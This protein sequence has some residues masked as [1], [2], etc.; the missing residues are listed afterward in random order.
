MIFVFLL[1]V[2]FG[3][4]SGSLDSF[5]EDPMKIQVV[6]SKK[7]HALDL[8]NHDIIVGWSMCGG[9]GVK[10][11]WLRDIVIS[12]ENECGDAQLKQFEVIG[13]FL[14]SFV[15]L[16]V[17]GKEAFDFVKF[18]DKSRELAVK[19]DEIGG[20][21]VLDDLREQLLKIGVIDL[22]QIL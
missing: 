14:D 1:L 16:D 17:V 12:V 2:F 21:D 19:G 9:S 18:G 4:E 20:F 7:L 10:V 13:S 8:A 3:V 11:V 15:E 5:C 22:H 6:V